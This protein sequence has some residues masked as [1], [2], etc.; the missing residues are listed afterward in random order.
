[1]FLGSVRNQVNRMMTV[2]GGKR[3]ELTWT[4][5]GALYGLLNRTVSRPSY[6]HREINHS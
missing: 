4:I 1:M 6:L 3:M 2:A 5:H